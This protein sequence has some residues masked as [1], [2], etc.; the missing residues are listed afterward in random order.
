MD[1]LLDLAADVLV[2]EALAALRQTLTGRFF[3]IVSAIQINITT[4]HAY[5]YRFL[6]EYSNFENL[7]SYL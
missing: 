4:D 3:S 7:D 5:D 1:D 6:L 2:A